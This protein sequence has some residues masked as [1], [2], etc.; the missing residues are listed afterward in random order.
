VQAAS[1]ALYALLLAGLIPRL[2]LAGVV[3]AH[4]ARFGVLLVACGIIQY[5]LQKPEKKRLIR[6]S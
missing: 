3:W 4:A 5:S 1:A 2:G 6:N